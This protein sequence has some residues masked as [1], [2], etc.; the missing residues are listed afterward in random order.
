M[1]NNASKKSRYVAIASRG[2]VV[3]FRYV[4]STGGVVNSA[5]GVVNST[6]GVVN[7]TG[8]VVN[9]MYCPLGVS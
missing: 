3:N 4:V 6:G 1:H 9:S 5:G 8:G 7:S 2:G